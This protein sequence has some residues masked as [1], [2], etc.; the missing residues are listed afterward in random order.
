M[1]KYLWPSMVVAP[2]YSP[3]QDQWD[4][5][6]LGVYITILNKQTSSFQLAWVFLELVMTPGLCVA[7]GA[8]ERGISLSHW[9]IPC[10]WLVLLLYRNTEFM[11]SCYFWY[12]VFF[13]WQNFKGLLQTYV[14]I[15][16]DHRYDLVLV[17][18]WY[19]TMGNMI[20]LR[21]YTQ[22]F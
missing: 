5:L 11:E 12:H 14:I 4:P 20:K 16:D 21:N 15:R 8:E 22:S 19:I 2:R 6:F 1:N 9:P 13:F 18:W 7:P 10:C 3:R 17:K